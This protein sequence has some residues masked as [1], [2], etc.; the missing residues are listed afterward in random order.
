MLSKD[1]GHLITLASIAGHQGVAGLV[2][3]C[4]SKHGAVGFNES[5]HRELI[6]LGSQVKTTCISPYYIDTGMFQGVKQSKISNLLPILQ[7][8]YV[9]ARI[10]EAV[11][12]DQPQLF[13]PRFLYIA[14]ALAAILPTQVWDLINHSH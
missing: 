5:I 6:H 7:P 9:V 12:T 10:V 4:A 8:E 2:D 13:L 3:Y 14:K 1:Y 11:L